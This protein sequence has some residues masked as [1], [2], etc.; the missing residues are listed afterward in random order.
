MAIESIVATHSKEFH[1]YFT[2]RVRVDFVKNLSSFP[3]HTTFKL[4]LYSLRRASY[5]FDD[6]MTR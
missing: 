2:V 3:D 5:L 6:F 4:E 1:V